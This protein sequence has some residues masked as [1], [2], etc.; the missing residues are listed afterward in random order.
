MPRDID[1]RLL[2]PAP[3][4]RVPA[5][6]GVVVLFVILTCLSVL[7][8][9]VRDWPVRLLLAMPF[10][11]FIPG[12]VVIAALFPEAESGGDGSE[13]STDDDSPVGRVRGRFAAGIGFLD[14]AALSF[15]ASIAI[16][17]LLGLLLDFTPWG[18]RLV[19]VVVAVA[20]FTLLTTV[21]AVVR[22]WNVP[23]SERFS[24]P[25]RRW[26]AAVRTTLRHPETRVDA[27]LNVV[28]VLCVLLAVASVGYAVTVP[29]EGENFTEFS[30]LS[31]ADNGTLTA[32]GYPTDFTAGERKPVYIAVKN[33]GHERERYTVVVLL[34][35]VNTAG[36]SA[37]VGNERELTRV[38]SAVDP[39]ETWR[40]KT[41][42]EPRITGDHLRI[43]YLLYDGHVP[44]NPSE[45]TASQEL[46]LWVN[47]SNG[48]KS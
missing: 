5:D 40:T 35:R 19:P 12:Y 34:Q 13:K 38:H 25:F 26:G 41:V 10:V 42:L 30:L 28:L 32:S 31:R 2:V 33:H 7:L 1:R 3:V 11:L 27:V 18:I 47:V 37:T 15:G 4:R 24:V 21:V 9:V 14:R 39:D 46:H 48:Q 43:Q 17:P 16:V 8:P 6:L 29:N 44:A 23:E 22:R 45:E 36:N 20:G